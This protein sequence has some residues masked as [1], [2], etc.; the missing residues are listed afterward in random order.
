MRKCSFYDRSREKSSIG[1]SEKTK[2][3][4]QPHKRA[5]RALEKCQNQSLKS[6]VWLRLLTDSHYFFFNNLVFSLSKDSQDK[7]LNFV[8]D[9]S[10]TQKSTLALKHNDLIHGT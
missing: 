5:L 2:T 8:P 9:V 6:Y 7:I 4:I 10:K 1:H 3:K